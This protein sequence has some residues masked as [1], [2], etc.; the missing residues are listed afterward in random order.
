VYA[1][2]SRAGPGRSDLPVRK[3]MTSVPPPTAVITSEFAKLQNTA[4]MRHEAQDAI[5]CTRSMSENRCVGLACLSSC[6][7]CGQ[8]YL[9]K[10]VLINAIMK[11]LNI[12]HE[13]SMSAACSSKRHVVHVLQFTY[14]VHIGIKRPHKPSSLRSCL[15]PAFCTLER[16]SDRLDLGRARG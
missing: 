11:N 8:T 12:A 13:L 3:G 14:S 7:S 6:T 2:L 16:T 5:I 9:S 1:Y 4:T 15:L 10:M